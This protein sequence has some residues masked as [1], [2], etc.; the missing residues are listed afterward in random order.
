MAQ[1]T[2]NDNS[3]GEVVI[4]PGSSGS[5]SGG[6]GFFSIGGGGGFGGGFGGSS[7]RRRK[8]R[9]RARAAALAQAQAEDQA[10]QAAAA[11][12]HA[13]ALARS[14]Q[15]RMAAFNQARDNRRA[16][17][18]THYAAQAQ[19]LAQALQ[20]EIDA[21]RTRPNHEG[22]E[23]WQ[24]Y[25]LTKARNEIQGLIAAKQPA[26]AEYQALANAFAG[27]D[28]TASSYA[29]RLA[30]LATAEQMQQLHRDWEAAYTAAHQARLLEE[31]IRQLS[32]R[33]ADLLAEHATQTQLWRQREALWEQQRQYA[34]QREARV[35][36]KQKAD[37][38]RRLQRLAEAA[39]LSAPVAAANAGGV[40]LT[41]SGAR[42]AL[43]LANA[44]SQAMLNARIELAR[45][46]AIRV[47]PKARL[48]VSAMVY[49]PRLGDGELTAEQRRQR[50]EGVGVGADLLGVEPG[51]DLQAIADAGGSARLASRIRVEQLAA[52]TGIAVAS[53]GSEISP[54][55]RV[56][57][58]VFDPLTETYRVQAETP[59]GKSIVLGGPAAP[60]VSAPA[61]RVLALE[62]EVSAI[63]AGMDLRFDD[64]IV[65]IPGQPPQYFSFTVPAAGTG[66][67]SGRGE[68]AAGNWWPG[69]R[70][71]AGVALPE[72]V[73]NQLRGRLFT[74]MDAFESAVWRAIAADQGL[75]GQFDELN[76]RRILSGFA[77]I[78]A[79]A[80]WSGAR[81]AFELRHVAAVG[82]GAGLYNLDQIR[83]HPPADTTGVLTAIQPFQPWFST[84]VALAFDS[85]AVPGQPTRTW[86]PLVAPGAEL[87]GPTG[88]PQAPQLPG[89]L[90]GTATDPVGPSLEILPGENPGE[91]GAIIPGFGGDTDLP[92]PG[93]VNNE[94]AK[95]LEVGEYRDLARRSINDRMDVDHIVSRKA[96]ERFL[97]KNNRMLEAHEIKFLLETAPSVVIPAAVHRKYSET[98][99]GRNSVERQ[100]KDASDLRAAVDSN[101]DA[102][103]PGLLEYG[104]SEHEIEQV[105]RELHALH[106]KK[107][108]SK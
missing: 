39:T 55:V 37:E 4:T 58:A 84:Q 71:A 60:A 103:R 38:D 30:G 31:A 7:R 98:Y 75:L 3:T 76:Q 14:Q 11:A 108:I 27:V 2:L 85:T 40:L 72:Q 28:A 41:H 82:V 15:E 83:I 56:R 90:P 50:L 69:N 43:E 89:M 79:K 47:G 52:G 29:S 65:C 80:S 93:V 68:V 26:L 64:C 87:L 16:Q 51:Q 62:P 53:T 46:T 20:S 24:L 49:S 12:A 9:A 57:N 95:P 104:F 105:R 22:G 1:N 8:K 78:A 45:V 35:D 36:H 96:Y 100:L 63:G 42:V 91:T 74:Q 32:Q 77:P 17:L 102:L 13:Q 10:R 34:V 25:L 70:A 66:V 48:F 99:G 88:L 59:A 21:A 33:S 6:G 107:G 44:I 61:G 106:Q 101:I 18:D 86:T 81:R 19:G 5:S 67:V 97:V 23:R 94:P 54:E 92:A 73:G